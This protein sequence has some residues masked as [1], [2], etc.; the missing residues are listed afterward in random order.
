MIFIGIFSLGMTIE[1]A[2]PPNHSQCRGGKLCH[3]KRQVHQACSPCCRQKMRTDPKRLSEE[4]PFCHLRHRTH[5]CS[6]TVSPSK[7]NA[8][9]RC[10]ELNCS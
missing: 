1:I 7:L 8:F 4:K 5:T 6:V 3:L 9:D 10:D 2:L